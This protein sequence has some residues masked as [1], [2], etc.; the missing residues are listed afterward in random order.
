ML[1]RR[2]LIEA[3]HQV[4][5]AYGGSLPWY[6]RDRFERQRKEVEKRLGMR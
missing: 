5:M 6:E 3:Q 1:I 2:P 4:E